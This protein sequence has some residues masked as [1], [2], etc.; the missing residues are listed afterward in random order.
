MA[1]RDPTRKLERRWTRVGEH[2]IH[3]WFAEE[4]GAKSPPIVL[5]HGFV[6][7]GRYFLPTAE[8]LAPFHPVNAPDLP[9]FGRSSK[10]RRV[11]SVPELADFLADWMEI[12]GLSRAVL[13][14][15][16]MGCQVIADLAARYPE[17]VERAVLASP[18]FEPGARTPGVQAWRLLLDLPRE[19]FSLLPIGFRDYVK[20]GLFRAWRTLRSALADPIE[21]KLP[22]LR[23]PTLVVRGSRDPIARQSWVE[24][25]TRL[26]PGGRLAVIPNG[27]HAVNYS[28]APEFAGLIR[29]FLAGERKIREQAGSGSRFAKATS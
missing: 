8:R 9:G 22:L 2:R 14:G 28:K 4:P 16:S 11:L 5:V 29:D 27:P 6:M 26:L 7:S 3:S 20:A 18:S 21:E 19:S 25:L 1:Q 10:P 15:H 13:V 24:E 12:S 17:R 23:A